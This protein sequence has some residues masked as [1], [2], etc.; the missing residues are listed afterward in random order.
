MSKYPSKFSE[1]AETSC[2]AILSLAGTKLDPSERAFFRDANPL[3]FILFKRNAEMPDQLY[4]LACS[5]KETL[6]RDC[7]VLI[8]QERG[9]VQ[10]LKPPNWRQ[11]PAMQEF[12]RQAEEDLEQ[13]LDSLRFTTLQMA[14]EL[15]AAG[16]N[17]TCAPV[18]DVLTAATHD[19]IGDRAFSSDPGIVAR[20]GLSMCRHYLASGITPVIKHIPG[21][22]RATVDSH[23]DLPVVREPLEILE[24]TDFLPFR[25]IA[26]AD[27]SSGI[28]AMAAHVIYTEID[29]H[30]P[31]SVSSAVIER[32]IRKAI[33]FT[34]LLVSDDLDMKALAAYGDVAARA[35]ISLEAGCDVALYCAGELK[36][37]EK[38]VKS[39][40]CLSAKALKS[41]QNAGKLKKVAA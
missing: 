33:G 25:E 13:A 32:V 21:H 27:C 14:E 26:A 17:V 10:G 22:G 2:A 34:G 18:L 38:L 37:M 41:L 6:G 30:H 7:P 3:G 19:A 39:V 28:W 15:L 9:R 8:D 5:L 36:I 31:A 16:I 35:K 23:H 40:P 4:G 12:G 29:P 1:G 11:Y 20:L 24:K